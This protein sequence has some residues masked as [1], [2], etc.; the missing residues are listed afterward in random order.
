[1]SRALVIQLARLGDLVQSLPAMTQLRA[2]HPETQ[3]DL[4][5]PSHLAEV[6]R[7]LPG[8]GKVLE[9]DGAA[10]QRRAM[11]VQEDLR[12][13]HLMEIETALAAL[14]PDRY[15]C[16]Y[17]LNQHRRAL[18]TGSLLAREMKGP[19]LHGPLGEALTPWAAYVRAVAQRR[20][21]QR[22]HL[23][24][25]F[26]GLCGVSPPGYVVTLD[27]PVVRLP[28]D[29][30][31]IGKRGAPWIALI[32]GAGEA[33]RC[34]P[35]EVW[36]R[37]INAFLA[38]SSQGRVVLVGAERERAAEIQASVPLSALGRIWDTTGRTSLSQLAAILARCHRV[39]GSDTGPLHLAAA[40]GRPV[41]GWYFARARVHET[42]PYG[43]HHVVWQ[44]E[45][46][47]REAFDVNPRNEES[48]P[49]ASPS[50]FH[51]SPSYWPVDETIAA[52]CEQGYQAPIGWTVWTSHCDTWGAYYSPVGQAAI[53]PREREAL[54]HELEPALS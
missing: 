11:A 14:A 19:L 10:W 36:R 31:P 45:D 41:I 26:C 24:D 34:V 39:V 43:F 33:E 48:K 27:P 42:G 47:R 5:C 30:E 28:D 53:P 1:M 22:V 8:L 37:W 4:L 9:W 40:L 15:D 3:F 18:V 32:V 12:A 50:A 2:R 25:A 51:A 7:L 46:V 35:A 6:G 49:V 17:V 44:A 29:L 52:I 13:D 38:S 21:G 16:A 54:W 23:A 20:L